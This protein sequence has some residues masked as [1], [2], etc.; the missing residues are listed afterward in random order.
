M[1]LPVF[2]LPAVLLSGLFTT[3]AQA[4]ASQAI[5]LDQIQIIDTDLGVA[6]APKCLRIEGRKI[7]LI[8]AAGAKACTRRST[9]HA[10]PGRY[11]MPGLI[12]MHAHLTLG[13]VALRSDEG[14]VT[15]TAL[16]DDDIA[17]HNAERLVAFGVTTVRNPGGDLAAAARYRSARQAGQMTGPESFAAGPVINN[18]DIE[19]LSVAVATVEDVQRTVTAQ[20]TAGADWIK[21]YTGLT[22]ALLKAG[23]DAAHAAGRPAVAHLDGIAWPDALAMGLD[24]IVHLMPTSPDLLDA[25]ERARWQ[26]AARPGTFSFFEW[27]EHFD[28][29]GPEADRL[30]AAF[31]RHQPVFDATLV[32]FHAAFVQDQDNPYRDEGRRLVH[33]RLLKGWNDGFTFAIDWQPDDFRRARAVWPKVQALARRIYASQAQ[34]TIGTDMGNPWVAPGI[35]LH[36]EMALLSEAGVSNARLLQAATVNAAQAL[37]AA[38]RFGRLA[39]GYEADVLVL[40]AN[41]LERIAHAQA[42][43]AVVLDGAM[44]TAARLAALKGE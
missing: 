15:V 28:P 25:T 17:R 9:V 27:W 8:A 34:V 11:L 39:P 44:L 2:V 37:G 16:P 3:M 1:R 4:A 43:E 18:T 33:P 22:P 6:S 26:A 29:D 23:I 32:A 31:D 10:L 5:S 36:Q 19:G 20:V 42:I 40:K 30:I 41:P 14:K 13:P 21:L 35:S 12:D 38:K 24:G 7:A